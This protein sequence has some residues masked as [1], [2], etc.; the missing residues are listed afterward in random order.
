MPQTAGAVRVPVA[1]GASW[2]QDASVRTARRLRALQPS[3]THGWAAQ[4][5][6]EWSAA[7]VRRTLC[8]YVAVCPRL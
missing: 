7:M 6:L 3:V 8:Q 2:G 4:P 1:V 5:R